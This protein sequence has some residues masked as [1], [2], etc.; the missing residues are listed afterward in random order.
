[1]PSLYL[2]IGPQG[3]GKSTWAA[4]HAARL[5]A[6]I[7]ASDEIRNELEAMEIDASTQGDRVFATLEERV[8]RLLDNSRSVI[9]DA[10]HARRKWRQNVLGI[11][12]KRGARCV[13]VWF[14]VPI[15]VMRQRNAGRPGGGWGQRVVPEDILLTV[16]RG[17]ERPTKNEFDEIWH[18]LPR[19]V[20]A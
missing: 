10:T 20:D 11:G 13:A 6:V 16:W 15:E 17:L 1:M 12:R 9:V 18:L 5:N 19:H 14:D 8:G 2:L 3:S 4:A 7:V